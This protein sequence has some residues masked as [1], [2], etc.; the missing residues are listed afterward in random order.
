MECDFYTHICTKIISDALVSQKIKTKSEYILGKLYNA[1]ILSKT[2]VSVG[3]KGIVFIFPF[4]KSSCEVLDDVIELYI[5]EGI[6]EEPE[7]YTTDVFLFDDIDTFLCNLFKLIKN[8]K[9]SLLVLDL[10]A[11]NCI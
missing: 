3:E 1:N 11:G 6:G 7:N 8:Y 2:D 5:G 10:N 9:G 4:V